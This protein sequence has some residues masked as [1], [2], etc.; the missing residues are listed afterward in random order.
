VIGDRASWIPI[1]GS[2]QRSCTPPR[3]RS[4]PARALSDPRRRNSRIHD[5]HSLVRQ[6]VYALALGYEDLN[7]HDELR[8]EVGLHTPVERFIDSFKAPPKQLILDFDATDDPVHGEHAGRLFHG[9]YRRYF[10]L[11]LYVFCAVAGQLPSTLQHRF[12]QAQLGD[13]GVVCQAAAPCL[14]PSA[15]RVPG[16]PRLLPLEVAAPV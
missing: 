7:D 10:F 12:G 13:P 6:R 5:A 8:R 2:P 1:A 9:Y 4:R 11:P 16:R 15:D 3:R 14:D